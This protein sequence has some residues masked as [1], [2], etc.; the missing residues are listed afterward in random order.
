MSIRTLSSKSSNMLQDL[1]SLF[2]S[3]SFILCLIDV[4]DPSST[5]PT[6]GQKLHSQQRVDREI[7]DAKDFENKEYPVQFGCQQN[8]L[9]KMLGGKNKATQDVI[10]PQLLK[11]KV[12]A[13]ESLVNHWLV[14]R[15]R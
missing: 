10:S 15:E 11:N 4:F 14:S 9:S 1:L 8:L 3:R 12:P 13:S 7:K 2:Q 5:V 6:D